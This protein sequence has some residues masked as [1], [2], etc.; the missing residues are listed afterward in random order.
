MASFPEQ[1]AYYRNSFQFKSLF[2]SRPTYSGNNSEGDTVEAVEVTDQ[3]NQQN[4]LLSV[5]SCNMTPEALYLTLDGQR[6][7]SVEEKK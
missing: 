1:P 4:P 3:N 7:E 2:A 6:N 5:V